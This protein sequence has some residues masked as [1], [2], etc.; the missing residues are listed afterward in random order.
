MS[1]YSNKTCDVLN[2]LSKRG[3]FVQLVSLR[4]DLSPQRR[5]MESLLLKERRTLI[6]GGADA[7]LIKISKAKLFVDGELH[8]HVADGTFVHV[9]EA[10]DS[11]QEVIHDTQ[12]VGCEHP[13]FDVGSDSRSSFLEEL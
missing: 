1:D 7:Q 12:E 6:S 3:S 10:T 9:R 5:I 2:I 4:Q 11:V 8:G 13:T